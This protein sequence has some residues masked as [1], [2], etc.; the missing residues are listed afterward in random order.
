M[1]RPEIVELQAAVEALREYALYQNLPNP[2]NPQ[3]TVRYD[4]P[5]VGEVNLVIYS[6]LGQ[7]VRT[8]VSEYQE[9]GA[10]H[11]KWDGKDAYQHDVS[12]GVYLLQMCA[13]HF[14]QTQKML[15]VR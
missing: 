7:A 8:L 5:E 15:L 6:A 4:L 12:S 14:V 3:T 10:Y 2:F 11:V 13:G 9:A 1:I